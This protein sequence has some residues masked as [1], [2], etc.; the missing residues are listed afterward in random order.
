V[1]H[2]QNHAENIGVERRGIAFRGLGGDRA[3][4]AFGAGI[5]HRDIETA[6]PFDGLVDESADVILYPFNLPRW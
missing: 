4:P 1:L 3:D 6:K 2:A 5:V